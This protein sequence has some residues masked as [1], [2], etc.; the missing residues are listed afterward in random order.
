MVTK[1]GL[2]NGGRDSAGIRKQE[3]C[4]WVSGVLLG[5]G[6]ERDVCDLDVRVLMKKGMEWSVCVAQCC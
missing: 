3:S 6:E 2:V 4:Q 1:K 5:T